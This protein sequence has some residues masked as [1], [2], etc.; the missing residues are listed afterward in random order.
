MNKE[1]VDKILSGR[2]IFTIICAGV[3]AIL[4]ITGKIPADKAVE[5]I[6]LVLVFYFTRN[7]RQKEDNGGVK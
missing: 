2:F 4:S 3:F 7:D 1:V 5:V 6:M